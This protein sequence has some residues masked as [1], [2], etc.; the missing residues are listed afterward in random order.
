M[1]SSTRSTAAKLSNTT[2]LPGT[3]GAPD[4]RQRQ[5]A[6]ITFLVDGTTG[7]ASTTDGHIYKTT[8]AA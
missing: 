5:A 3:A 6:D 8:D 7:F 2:G 4:W 1:R